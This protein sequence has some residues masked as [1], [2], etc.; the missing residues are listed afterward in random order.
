MRS[1]GG[2]TLATV[3]WTRALVV[4][5]TVALCAAGLLALVARAPA[6]LRRYEPPP[7]ATDPERGTRFST[8]EVARA[9]AYNGPRYLGVALGA[10]V[11]CT[12]LVVLVRGPFAGLVR[13]LAPLPGGWVA[14]AVVAA[15]ILAAL[16]AAVALPLAFVRWYAI[17]HAW[18]LSTQ[19]VG[20]WLL[21]RGRSLGVGAVV[22]AVG[23]VAFF[24]VARAQPR[25][26][27]LWGWLVFTV[28]QA[29]LVFLWPVAIAPLF[30]RFSPLP[31]G[32]L[33]AR[34]T[35]LGKAAGVRVEEVLVA[36]A[37][38]RT[39]T[40]NA[41]VAGLGATKRVVV[42]DNL[43]EAGDED[44][45]LYVVAH[46][47]G[48]E[49][50]S[51]VL[52]G[53]VLS[54]AG[55]LLGFAVLGWLARREAV[56]AAVDAAGIGDLGVLPA[57]LLYATLAGLLAL[58]IESAVSRSFERRADEIA[59]EL[60][61]DRATAVRVLRRLALSN[62]SDLDPPPAAVAFLYSHP[63]VRERIR[64][65]LSPSPGAP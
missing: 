50:E 59:L 27:W 43:L 42:Y 48:H 3:S 8:R 54:S 4:A 64:A 61:G 32:S 25:A 26:W 5:A 63:P 53:V 23:A 7:R 57:L 45:T 10:V 55:L 19:G 21:D 20:A 41:Y 31:D 9:A 49:A 36:D 18:G 15:I 30:N 35:S 37:S 11:Q 24:A 34:I 65:V 2:P 13:A 58:P 6:S 46:E 39:T 33:A 17:D 14:R 44:E 1:Q 16:S 62:I 29:V 38:R 47:L 28:L 60:T 56:L 52:K 12:L 40:E 22:G 51:H